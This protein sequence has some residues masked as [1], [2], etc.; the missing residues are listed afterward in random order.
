MARHL[1]RLYAAVRARG[2]GFGPRLNVKT[3]TVLQARKYVLHRTKPR[4]DELPAE[5]KELARLLDDV[6]PF[7][8]SEQST[9]GQCWVAFKESTG[10]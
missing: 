8:V 10:G 6:E 1:D 7:K 2:D 4:A 5:V 3:L 9:V